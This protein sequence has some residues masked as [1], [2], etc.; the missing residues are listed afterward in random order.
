MYKTHV[1]AQ[2]DYCDNLSYTTWPKSTTHKYVPKFSNGKS[3][4]NPIPSSSCHYWFLE[5][6]KSYH[7]LRGIRMEILIWPSYMSAYFEEY[8]F[9]SK[10]KIMF[11]IHNPG[12]LQYLFSLESLNKPVNESKWWYIFNDT[13]YE[14]CRC[15]QG[16]DETSNFKKFKEFDWITLYIDNTSGKSKN[17]YDLIDSQLQSLFPHFQVFMSLWIFVRLH[18][19]SGLLFEQFRLLLYMLS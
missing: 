16:I 1:R 18:L 10:T 13:H 5:W 17:V 8:L 6:F 12:G 3:R 9:S 2:F 14:I 4:Q 15:N 7:N 11:D 19:V